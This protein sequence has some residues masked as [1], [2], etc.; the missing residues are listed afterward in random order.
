MNTALVSVIIV[1]WNGKTWLPGCLAAI[2]QQ[3]YPYIEVIVVDNGSTDGSAQLVEG[4]YPWV[5]L[6]P[7]GRNVGFAA[8]NNL[9]FAAANGVYFVTLNNDTAIEP[10][11]VTELVK[12][13]QSSADVG[14]VASKMLMWDD[15][16]RIDS[17]GIAL[18]RAGLAWNRLRGEMDDRSVT[19]PSD[20]FGPCAGAA[21]YRRELIEQ[22]GGFDEDFFFYYED[23]DLAWRAQRA[24]WRC[25]YVPTARVLH[26]HSATGA[27]NPPLKSYL[28]G[29][30]KMWALCKNVRG[31]WIAWL[32]LILFYDGCAAWYALLFRHDPYSLKGRLAAWGGAWRMRR[33]PLYP[34]QPNPTLL[35]QPVTHWQNILDPVRPPWQALRWFNAPDVSKTTIH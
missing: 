24:G 35:A 14:M 15:P 12:A 32:P 7:A 22:L 5:R 30:N 6:A 25:L 19:R 2:Q 13:A 34:G 10:D 16:T 3:T 27:Q 26:R 9:G 1:S 8:G 23:V 11:F 17:A 28:L 21:L 29:R 18:N 33:K 4:A 20:I 31:S